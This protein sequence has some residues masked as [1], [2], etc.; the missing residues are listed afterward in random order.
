MNPLEPLLRLSGRYAGPSRLWM[1]PDDPPHDCASTA[2]VSG[3]I[4]DRFV[5]IDYRWAFEGQPQEGRLLLGY[6]AQGEGVTIVWADTW[7]MGD[8]LMV[9]RGQ[10]DPGGTVAVRGSYAAPPGPDWGWR[11][12]IAPAGDDAFQID[13]YNVTPDG[14]EALAVRATYERNE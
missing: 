7:H 6:E 4:G 10:V 8:A 5:Q 14:Q 3:A 2:V 13:M 11:I 12:E 9:C 1:S